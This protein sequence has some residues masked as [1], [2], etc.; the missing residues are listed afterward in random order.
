LNQTFAIKEFKEA[1][2][3]IDAKL[4][5]NDAI[6]EIEANRRLKGCKNFVQYENAYL[7]KRLDKNTGSPFD[8]PILFFEYVS[9][10]D[11]LKYSVIR[12]NIGWF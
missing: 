8:V 4:I 1:N 9:G 3:P 6:G 7:D 11:L 2:S 5:V 10:G 12:T